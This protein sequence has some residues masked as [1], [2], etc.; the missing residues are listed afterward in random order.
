MNTVVVPAFLLGTVEMPFV[1]RERAGRRGASSEAV[2]D[3]YARDVI[4][5]AW[6]GAS[7]RLV[8]VND[9]KDGFVCEIP[10]K[11]Q[12]AISNME[13]MPVRDRCG[14]EQRIDRS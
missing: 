5:C 8:D 2:A 1:G 14:H 10:R 12:Q 6:G 3:R 13:T 4:T 11:L 9:C 7:C